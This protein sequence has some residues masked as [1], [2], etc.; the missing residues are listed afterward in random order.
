[1]AWRNKPLIMSFQ[2]GWE[3]GLA[4]ATFFLGAAVFLTL[5]AAAAV[6]VVFVL[7]TFFA[8][9]SMGAEAEA[10]TGEGEAEVA[11]DIVGWRIWV[12]A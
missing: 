6:L 3:T 8:G 10:G 9:A 1:M 11:E 7:V 5:V 2:E 4:A 12:V